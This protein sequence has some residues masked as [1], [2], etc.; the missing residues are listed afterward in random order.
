MA[1]PPALSI[2]DLSSCFFSGNLP[3]S[4]SSLTSLVYVPCDLLAG[5]CIA[6]VL[7]VRAP[8]FLI[9]TPR[10]GAEHRR[11]R[12]IAARQLAGGR[13][14]RTGGLPECECCHYC[15]IPVK[16]MGR[17]CGQA[18]LP[19]RGVAVALWLCQVA[20]AISRFEPVTLA[21]TATSWQRARDMVAAA[22]ALATGG[23]CV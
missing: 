2:F 3:A 16:S 5:H 11:A 1:F 6:P 20:L 12:R 18:L 15:A 4:M 22:G 8:Y 21:A 19:A 13:R 14:T 17:C 23:A 9:R 7:L 10:R